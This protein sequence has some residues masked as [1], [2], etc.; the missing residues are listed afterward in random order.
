MIENNT[1]LTIFIIAVNNA[2][3]LKYAMISHK[4]YYKILNSLKYLK[5]L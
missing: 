4:M 1:N 2:Q 3:I 5:I